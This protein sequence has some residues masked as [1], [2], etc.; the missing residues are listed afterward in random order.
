MTHSTLCWEHSTH[1]C[2]KL[3]TRAWTHFFIHPIIEPPLV[4]SESMESN[5]KKISTLMI[6][7][8]NWIVPVKYPSVY[9]SVCLWI[10]LRTK[11]VT[12]AVLCII[13]PLWIMYTLSLRFWY[14]IFGGKKPQIWTFW[15]D[16]TPVMDIF[17]FYNSRPSFIKASQP[18][19][20]HSYKELY[21][22]Q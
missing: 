18:N 3:I 13:C 22:L 2:C 14:A 15:K 12:G 9:L 10:T 7:Y 6:C 8:S 17:L 1:N 4:A 5:K 20:G 11:T 16:T 19:N 21:F